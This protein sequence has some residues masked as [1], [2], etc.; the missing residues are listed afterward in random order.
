MELKVRVI[1]FLVVLYHIVSIL[2][3]FVVLSWYLIERLDADA[4]TRDVRLNK[5]IM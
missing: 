3:P 1:H 2:A 4:V 5:R